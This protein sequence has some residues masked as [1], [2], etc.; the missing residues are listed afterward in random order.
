MLFALWT[1]AA[2]AAPTLELMGTCPGVV[3]IDTYGGTPGGTVVVVSGNGPGTTVIPSGACMGTTLD[4]GGAV[5]ARATLTADGLGRAFL[6][7]TLGAPECAAW[8]QVL[9]LTTC[10][11]TQAMPLSASTCG[12]A[13]S[14]PIEFEDGILAGNATGVAFVDATSDGL[15]D[16]VAATGFDASTAVISIFS[17]GAIAGTILGDAPINLSYP[18]SGWPTFWEFTAGDLDNDTDTD[19]VAGGKN[20][21]ILIWGPITSSFAISSANSVAITAVDPD[22]DVG[23]SMAVADFTGDSIPDL[24]LGAPQWG[25]NNSTGAAYVMS[26]PILTDRT[27]NNA[28][29]TITGMSSSDRTGEAVVAGDFD[30]DGVADLA[31][32]S[33]GVALVFNGGGLPGSYTTDL[34][35]HKLIGLHTRDPDILS[36]GDVNNDGYADLAGA[37]AGAAWIALGP[38]LYESYSDDAEIVFTDSTTAYADSVD[39]TTDLD[40]DGSLD[41]LV[42]EDGTN[43][44]VHL[45]YAPQPGSYD[46]DL[47]DDARFMKG[48]TTDT[49]TLS[50]DVNRDGRPDVA[51]WKKGTGAGIYTFLGQP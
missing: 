9:D 27:T 42:D 50:G 43:N 12:G 1:I 14:G 30:G 51:L 23:K 38:F 49:E 24:L 10:A 37:E 39:I 41:L 17:G 6:T 2:W 29:I 46:G 33:D 4:L 31:T 32:S 26:G 13:F 18:G 35:D 8:L 16:M 25:S 21:A 20:E 11:I 47:D 44:V 48:V 19:L 45:Y 34:Y 28:L 15:G 22:D 36:A 3:G 7:P 5:A 40:C